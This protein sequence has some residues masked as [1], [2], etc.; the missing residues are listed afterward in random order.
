[1]SSNKRKFERYTT[2]FIDY[3]IATSNFNEAMFN[4][5]KNGEN[6]PDYVAYFAHA[7]AIKHAHFLDCAERVFDGRVQVRTA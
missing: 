5:S 2:A 7:L 1:M 3:Q 4:A 6:T